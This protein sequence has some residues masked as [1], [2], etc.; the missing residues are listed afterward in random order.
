VRT[1][2]AIIAG[3]SSSPETRPRDVASGED[4]FAVPAT[5]VRYLAGTW[6]FP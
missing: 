1:K 2:G 6:L 5:G 3:A 4:E